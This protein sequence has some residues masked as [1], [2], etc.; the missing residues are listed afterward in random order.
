MTEDNLINA[1][2]VVVI[3]KTVN[4]KIPT[5]VFLSDID[6]GGLVKNIIWSI[7]GG[8]QEEDKFLSDDWQ[9]VA[10][11]M[12]TL[13]EVPLLLKETSD[14]NEIKKETENFIK[15]INKSKGAVIIN[16]K[17]IQVEDFT[18]KENISIIVLDK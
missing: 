7:K 14:L 5:V 2:T 9:K 16:A 18:T 15:E 10:E 8:N 13:A 1:I 4:Q 12:Q 3:E 17:G 6:K 11:I